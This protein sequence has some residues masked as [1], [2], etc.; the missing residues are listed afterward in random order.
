MEKAWLDSKGR[1][2]VNWVKC[3]GLESQEGRRVG[4]RR[5]FKLKH[6]RAV[7]AMATFADVDMGEDQSAAL[8]MFARIGEVLS[9]VI[10]AWDWV[11]EDGQPLP[12]PEGRPEV[13][14]ELSFE[15]LNWL[16]ARMGEAVGS[17]NAVARAS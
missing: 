15:E 1:S 8:D 16:I 12:Q 10:L 7:A 4:F 17:K 13:F 11:N 9:Q 3:E 6:L 5:A 14:E 2:M